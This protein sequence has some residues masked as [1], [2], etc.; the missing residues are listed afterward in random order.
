TFRGP[1][2]LWKRHR[3]ETLATPEAF[4]RDPRL[5][6]EWYAWRRE[7]VSSCEPNAAHRAIARFVRARE[8]ARVVTQNVDGLHA[9]A[10]DELP[11][12]A[13]NALRE[14]PV[15]LHGSLFRV[16]CVRCDFEEGHTGPVDA[17]A[18]ERLP[19]CPRCGELLRPA[20]VWFGESLDPR[21]L[22]EAFR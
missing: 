8:H 20:V 14:A 19:R 6:W 16:R 1:E 11:D 10:A 2:G 15:E 9:R 18:T 13:A 4:E 7:R 12:P 22:E 3:P 17:S 5:V 21:V